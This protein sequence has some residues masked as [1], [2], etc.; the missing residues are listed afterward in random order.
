MKI[1][2]PGKTNLRVFLTRL[3]YGGADFFL[4]TFE[5]ETV[6]IIF[7]LPPRVKGKNNFRHRSFWDFHLLGFGEVFPP[8]PMEEPPHH[9]SRRRKERS[10]G[11]YR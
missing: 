6:Y 8:G 5:N 7:F 10:D 1:H 11:A 9:P 2:L 4:T 3:G